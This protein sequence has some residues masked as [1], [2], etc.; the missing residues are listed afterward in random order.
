MALVAL[1]RVPASA[2]SAILADKRA[3]LV[4]LPVPALAVVHQT[5]VAVVSLDG[6]VGRRAAPFWRLVVLVVTEGESNTQEL[7]PA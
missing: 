3:V 4:E 2:L 5:I 1:G 6:P 7:W